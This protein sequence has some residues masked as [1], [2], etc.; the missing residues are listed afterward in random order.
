MSED[1]SMTSDLKI[2]VQG[3]ADCVKIKDKNG[4]EYKLQPLDLE[5][6]CEYEDRVGTSLLALNFATLKLKDISYML[7]LSIRKDGLSAQEVTDRKFKFSETEMRRRFDLALF[8]R[9][10]IVVTDLLRISG[11][12]MKA[13]PQEANPAESAS[14]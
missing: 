11:L 5:D 13:N 6:L 10:A 2:L 9:T 7:Y 1:K 12:E 3:T 4:G 8:A 14:K